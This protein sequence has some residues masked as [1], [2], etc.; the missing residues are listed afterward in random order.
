MVPPSPV[1]I[2]G[3]TLV[4]LMIGMEKAFLF[5]IQPYLWGDAMKLVV[6]ACLMPAAWR[7]VRA[8]E[9]M[10]SDGRADAKSALRHNDMMPRQ[11]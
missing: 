2:T 3:Q 4:V 11:C 7:G 9:R 8:V 10:S 1:P 5:G 6:A